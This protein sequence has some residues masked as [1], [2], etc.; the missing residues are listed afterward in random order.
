MLVIYLFQTVFVKTIS[1][2]GATPA[3]IA[4]FS[5]MFSFLAPNDKEA[6]YVTVI[7]AV[8]AG[9]CLGRVFPFEVLMV[10]CGSVAARAL[11]RYMRFISRLIRLEV[12]VLIFS[13]L[14]IFA[15][16]YIENRTIGLGV[17]LYR[18]LPS[19]GYT[20]ICTLVM[21]P[22]MQNTLFK[23]KEKKLSLI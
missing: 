3:L 15:G 4:A 17:I 10:G 8:L 7:C 5:V 16:Y 21:Y 23:T 9:S 14:L 1:I 11:V 13:A 22:I 2:Y 18:L 19:L 12:I 20:V 6:A